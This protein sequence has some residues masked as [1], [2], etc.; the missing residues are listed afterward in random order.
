MSPGRWLLGSDGRSYTVSH[1][2][3][4]GDRCLSF[5]YSPEFF[6]RIAD[7]AGMAGIGFGRHELPP[8]R[9]FAPLTARALMTLRAT[10]SPN[11]SANAFEEISLAV[12]G[13]ALQLSANNRRTK[14]RTSAQ[15]RYRVVR[16]LRQIEATPSGRHSLAELAHMADLSRYYFLRTFAQVTGL[17]P[18][19]WILRRRLQLAAQHLISSGQPVTDIAFDAGFGDLSNFIRTFRAEFGI[20]PSRYRAAGVSESIGSRPRPK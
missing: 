13:T 3:G 12:A 4:E 6:E 16:V 10:D 9:A 8:L 15:D 14:P 20:S 7:G 17:T 2:H 5:Q 18:R 11:S 19:Q 1:E